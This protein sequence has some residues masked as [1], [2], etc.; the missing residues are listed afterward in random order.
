MIAT[1]GTIL[2]WVMIGI[3]G[4]VLLFYAFIGLMF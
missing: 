1:T 3:L 4:A 2:V